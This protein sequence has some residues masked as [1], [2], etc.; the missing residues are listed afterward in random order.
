CQLASV[1]RD[2][3]CPAHH[4]PAVRAHGLSEPS[5]WPPREP[6][7]SA[8]QHV[9]HR[10]TGTSF[11]LETTNEGT[12]LMLP[13]PQ[14]YE[15]PTHAL[16]G[17]PTYHAMSGTCGGTI[18]HRPGHPCCAGSQCSPDGPGYLGRRRTEE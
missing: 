16:L 7:S 10:H 18:C 17:H 15:C 9:P 14:P 4:R 11:L 1:A 5:D 2:A 8:H 12:A 3:D 13:G 6:V